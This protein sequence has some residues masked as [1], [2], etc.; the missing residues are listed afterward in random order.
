MAGMCWTL[1]FSE[2]AGLG[3][4]ASLIAS[5]KG[6]V[7]RKGQTLGTSDPVKLS[8]CRCRSGMI[9]VVCGI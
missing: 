8:C 9:E 1:R 7:Y 2:C 6:L 4:R 3:S 5:S